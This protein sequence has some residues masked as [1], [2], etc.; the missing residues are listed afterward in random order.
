MNIVFVG[1]TI[2]VA[3]AR[4]ILDAWYLPPV[5]QGDVYRAAQHR[6]TAIGIVDGYFDQVP[7][8]WHKEIL[9]AM[10][11]GIKVFGSA[12]MGALRAAELA[13][14]G[15]I[16]IGRVFEAFAT[17]E[18]EDDDE[19][20]VRHGSIDSGYRQMSE[21]MVNIRE[22]LANAAAAG[23]LSSSEVTPLIKAI[24]SIPYQE[25][26]T[27]AIVAMA[28]ALGVD[29]SRLQILGAWLAG[30]RVDRKRADAV[31]MLGAMAQSSSDDSRRAVNFSFEITTLW[32]HLT[33]TAG[34]L[35][36]SADNGSAAKNVVDELLID[37]DD[38]TDLALIATARRLA[39]VEHRMQNA[40]DWDRGLDEAIVRFRHAKGLRD[41]E[42]LQEWLRLN[43][44]SEWD[45][46]LLME[47]EA[48]VKN[49]VD[50]L[51]GEMDR[52]LIDH[53]RVTGQF[54]ALAARASAKLQLIEHLQAAPPSREDYDMA[55]DWF[56]NTKS[57]PD[58]DD[59]HRLGFADVAPFKRA[60]LLE[61]LS[62]R[63]SV[64]RDEQ[65]KQ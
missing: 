21:A 49:M 65:N 45:F 51:R 41:P 5:S 4:D 32:D 10:A 64:G 28:G 26:N 14:F 2:G 60:V 47:R 48:A 46:L 6:P 39:L 16:G 3:Q 35:A 57:T 38:W 59:G 20:A 36:M 12:S 30:N 18:L 1:P 13:R 61:F 40:A 53:L 9:W 42:Q 23:V 33:R 8:V 54:P 24:K 27:H 62:H 29:T 25:R 7:S 63:E 34:H 58:L 50:R 44:L 17:G 37:C 56:T 52:E 11:Q 55:Y 22:T 43:E 19:V 15:M 31:E